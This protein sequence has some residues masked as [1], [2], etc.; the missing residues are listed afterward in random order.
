MNYKPIVSGSP[1]SSRLIFGC[2]GL[3]G[4]VGKK[5]SLRIVALALERGIS[6]FDVARSYGYGDAESCL[7]EALQGCRR[8]VLITGKFGIQPSKRGTA[9]RF[10]KPVAQGLLAAFPRIRGVIR[11]GVKSAGA[12]SVGGQF[13]LIDSMRSFETSLRALRTYYIDLLLMH[14]CRDEDVT[15]GMIEFLES[16]KKTGK[17]RAYGAATTLETAREI[18]KRY[19]EKFIFQ[20]QDSVLRRA[21]EM[22]IPQGTFLT[23][24][25]LHGA[26]QVVRW[27]QEDETELTTRGL[28]Q[29]SKEDI[30]T[31]MLQ[32]GLSVNPSGAVVCSMLNPE[33]LESNLKVVNN[34]RFSP[35]QVE[36]FAKWVADKTS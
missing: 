3:M 21:K 27:A 19:P 1:E 28:S 33:H 16:L 17:I 20:F 9:L 24:G 26:D 32:Y 15:D 4:R 5:S 18:E 8:Q 12:G 23:Y 35:R 7:G 6:H 11:R 25:L 30:F 13:D 14:D 10:L 22:R 34:P 31:L 2:S 36:T 29:L